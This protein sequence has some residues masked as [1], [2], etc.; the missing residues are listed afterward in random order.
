MLRAHARVYQE[1]LLLDPHFQEQGSV[2]KFQHRVLDER[3][4]EPR[5]TLVAVDKPTRSIANMFMEKKAG[6]DDRRAVLDLADLLEQVCMLNP[7]NR[8]AVAECLKHRF[9]AGRA[10]PKEKAA[11]AAAAAKDASPPPPDAGSKSPARI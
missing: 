11:A 4:R 7:D 5:L 6:A 8:P 1:L 3:T 9:V 10:D 2:F